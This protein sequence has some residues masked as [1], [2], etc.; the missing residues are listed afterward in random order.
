MTLAAGTE[1]YAIAVAGN[2]LTFTNGFK[3]IK[4]TKI[5]DRNNFAAV[6]WSTIV[7]YSPALALLIEQK[8]PFGLG[9]KQVH[10]YS[11]DGR[12]FE[13]EPTGWILILHPANTFE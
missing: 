3:S 2:G 13:A 6:A 10:Y 4:T 11:L 7:S 9:T 5:L 1:V 12:F 8:R